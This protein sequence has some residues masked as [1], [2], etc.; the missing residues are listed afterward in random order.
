MLHAIL[1]GKL[2]PLTADAQRL[3]DALTSTVFGTLTLVDRWD[4]LMRWLGGS[5]GQDGGAL[6]GE[7]WYWPTLRTPGCVVIPDVVVRVSTQLFVVEAKYGSGRNDI[8]GDAETPEQVR[9]QLVRQHICISVPADQRKRYP[10]GI[11]TA[12]DQYAAQ[13]VFLVD[14]RRV[15]SARRELAE[16]VACEPRMK[17]RL[18]TWQQLDRL[19]YEFGTGKRWATDLRQFMELEGL[20]AFVG[21]NES[22]AVPVSTFVRCE[23]WRSAGTATRSRNVMSLALRARVDRIAGWK[24]TSTTDQARR[25]FRMD[26]EQVSRCR[27]VMLWRSVLPKEEE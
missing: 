2:S 11:E 20:S 1:H 9:D 4:V 16:S 12:L 8:A 14:A 13:Q 25:W 6:A 27:T 26:P 7:V 22:V 17:I 18:V 10:E 19:L 24:P 15:R 23:G 21:F 5:M 3:E